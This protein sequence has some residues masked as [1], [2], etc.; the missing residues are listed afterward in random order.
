M[1][2]TT[3]PF[4]SF[5]NSNNNN[6]SNSDNTNTPHSSSPHL[7]THLPNNNPQISYDYEAEYECELP[8]NISPG[9][10]DGFRKKQ[11]LYRFSMADWWVQPLQQNKLTFRT[12]ILDLS[13]DEGKALLSLHEE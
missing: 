5:P 13:C 1:A 9:N 4:L 7:S 3:P 2:T 11:F 6:N 10:V 12:Q 8:P